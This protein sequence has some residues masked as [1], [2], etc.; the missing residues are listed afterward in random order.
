LRQELREPEIDGIEDCDNHAEIGL[1]AA[2]HQSVRSALPAPHSR[3]L[4]NEDQQTVGSVL[5]LS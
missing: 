3:P 5:D 4:T 1:G 2:D